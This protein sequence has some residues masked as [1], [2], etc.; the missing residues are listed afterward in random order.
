[1]SKKSL[2]VFATRTASIAAAGSLLVG[3]TAALPNAAATTLEGYETIRVTQ[4][5]G[6]N[7]D[8]AVENLTTPRS[9]YTKKPVLLNNDAD[10]LVVLAGKNTKPA[11]QKKARSIPGYNPWQHLAPEGDGPDFEDVDYANGYSAEKLFT[12]YR[13]DVPE[14]ISFV[15]A[16]SGYDA[17]INNKAIYKQNL[18][19]TIAINN[20]ASKVQIQRAVQDSNEEN[21]ST[22]SDAMGGKMGKIFRDLYNEGKLPKLQQLIG[23]SFSRAFHFMNATGLEKV[24]YRNPRPFAVAQDRIKYYY[25]DVDDAI[26][27][28]GYRALFWSYP[29]GHTNRAYIKGII[30]A[31]MLPEIAPQLMARASEVGY[32]RI[33]MGVHYPLDVIAGRI[34]ST[35]SMAQHWNDERFRPLFY[36]AMRELRGSLEKQC[37]TTIAKCTK[38]GLQWLDTKES[39]RVYTERMTYGFP[40]IGKTGVKF[41]VPTYAEQL[42]RTIF[43]KLTQ[44]QRRMVL[45][46]TAMESGYPLDISGPDGGWQRV[47]FA[48][49]FAAKVTVQPDGSLIINYPKV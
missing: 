18:E 48:K 47:N 4:K 12:L 43:P 38:Q 20:N 26:E 5:S 44:Q 41:T 1:M 2:R 45:A 13:S 35:A 33:V 3:L 31:T 22:M 23:G 32:N 14:G 46:A 42:L 39:V 24:T 15:N 28:E 30:L 11:D 49:A 19:T 36:E 25:E 40:K 21:I 6:D 17:A 7:K 34:T 10:D 8:I 9:Q 27:D 16:I 29:S 37:G